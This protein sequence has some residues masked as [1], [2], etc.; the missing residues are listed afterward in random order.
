[1][2]QKDFF[3]VEEIAELLRVTVSSVRNRLSRGDPTLP[4]SLR[5]GGRRLF[6]VAAYQKWIK[7]MVEPQDCDQASSPP[8]PFQHQQRRGRPRHT[9]GGLA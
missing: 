8:P 4:P 9:S 2:T 1:M 7:H 5:V 3:T 6:P